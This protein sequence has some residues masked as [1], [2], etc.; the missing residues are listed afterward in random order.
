MVPTGTGANVK[1]ALR[2]IRRTVVR[3]GGQ[4]NGI[5]EKKQHV[6]NETI[7]DSDFRLQ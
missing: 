6:L 2:T 7:Y 3:L 4:R 1:T 5:P